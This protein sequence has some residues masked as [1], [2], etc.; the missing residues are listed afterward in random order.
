MEYAAARMNMVESQI[1]PNKVRDPAVIAAFLEVPRERFVPPALQGVA[2]VD[3]DVPIGGGR[4]LVEPMVLARLLQ[5]AAP[6]PHERAL[7]IGSATGYGTALLARMVA[8]VVG[9]ER[10]SELARRANDNLAA[11]GIDNAA[12]LV[13][14]FLEGCP[15]QAPFDVIVYGGAVGTV[16][17]KV[18][19]QLSEGGRLV[20][21]ETLGGVGRA[22]LLRRQGGVLSRRVV[23]DAATPLLPGTEAKPEFVF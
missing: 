11:L 20:A 15:A 16:P 8:A 1:R 10:D 13:G 4:Y 12:V 23:F 5:F 3:E 14:D 22:V 6:Q 2:Y 7:E 18:E 21:V 17:A 9:I 19:S